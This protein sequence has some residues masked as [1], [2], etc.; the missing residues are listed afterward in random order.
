MIVDLL[1]NDLGKY[2]QI[3][4]VKTPKRFAIE[5]FKMCITWSALLQRR[6]VI[7]IQLPSYSARCQLALSRVHPKTG[8]RDYP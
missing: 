5:S 3:G 6:S 4:T 7:R 8:M 1:R 2:A